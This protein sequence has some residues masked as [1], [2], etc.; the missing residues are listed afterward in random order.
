METRSM[1]ILAVAA[2]IAIIGVALYSG[3]QDA[4]APA[5]PETAT[6][7]TPSTSTAPPSA[8]SETPAESPTNEASNTE[9]ATTGS[10]QQ[11]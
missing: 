1:L 8:S 5:T 9:P 11:N 3:G 4:P 6:S 10:G 2:V 7:P